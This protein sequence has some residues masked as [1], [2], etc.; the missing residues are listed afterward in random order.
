[1]WDYRLPLCLFPGNFGA[2]MSLDQLDQLAGIRRLRLSVN[3]TR[4][5]VAGLRGQ[6]KSRLPPS[7]VPSLCFSAA[8][9]LPPKAFCGRRDPR[10]CP[11]SWGLQ[12]TGIGQPDTDIAL[13][14]K[15]PVC[16]VCANALQIRHWAMSG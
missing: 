9:R 6:G 2:A 7:M 4:L 14:G 3:F 1:M 11:C 13:I 12:V 8:Q 15:C 16:P 10:Y 5:S